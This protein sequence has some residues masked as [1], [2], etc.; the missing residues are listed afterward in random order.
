MEH[1][2]AKGFTV[3]AYDHPAHGG[4]DGVHGHIPAFV[5]GLEAIPDSVGEV[6]GLVGHSM[7]TASALECKHVKLETNLVANCTCV[8]LSR[9]PVR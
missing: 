7:G 9:K 5:N 4:S 2:A 3:M 1:I 6:A 8:G